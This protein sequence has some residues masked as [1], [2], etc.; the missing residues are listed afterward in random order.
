MSKKWDAEIYFDGGSRGNPG[1]SAGGAIIKY[2]DK[3][4]VVEKFLA[5]ATVNEAEYTGC[6][7]GLEKALELGCKNI[8][9]FGDSQLVI[10]Q[11]QGFWKVK[12]ANLF[13]Y[14]QQAFKLSKQF[15]QCQTQWIR[16]EHN[17]EAD[18]I[19]NQ[20]MDKNTRV[21]LV[22]GKSIDLQVCE[23]VTELSKQ[24]QEIAKLGEKASFKHFKNLKS[25][26]DKFSGIKLVQLIESVPVNVWKLIQQSVPEGEEWQ[27]KALRWYLRGLPVEHCIH[28]VKV[29]WEIN[30]NAVRSKFK[31]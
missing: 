5:H 30:Q 12:A 21:T 6:I 7:L 23:P 1:P 27:T 11:L 29:D 22:R 31:K 28:K 24:I 16:R 10:N 15:S 18:A 2:Q 14:Y 13:D 19:C 3:T 4:Y 26:N 20:C 8:K 17:Q 25:G 9:L